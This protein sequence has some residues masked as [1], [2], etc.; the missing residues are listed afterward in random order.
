MDAPT[1]AS[2]AISRMKA[3]SAAW[4]KILSHYLAA[5]RAHRQDCDRMRGPEI[6]RKQDPIAGQIG[7]KMPKVT[8]QETT[9]TAEGDRPDPDRP[10]QTPQAR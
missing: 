10:C 4:D 5:E 6:A 9:V 2:N 7:W 3:V 1:P 8:R